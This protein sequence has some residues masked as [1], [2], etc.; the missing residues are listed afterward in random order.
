MYVDL[1]IIE[2]TYVTESCFERV[3][4]LLYGIT[5][6]NMKRVLVSNRHIVCIVKFSCLI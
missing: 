4:Q 1:N 5:F 2:F 6:T 3:L